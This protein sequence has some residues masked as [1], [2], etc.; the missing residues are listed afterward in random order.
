MAKKALLDV[1]EQTIGKYVKNL[2]AESLNVAVWSGKIELHSL[3]LDVE[4]VNNELDRQAAEAPNL[5]LPF[6]VLSGKFEAFEVD[7]PWSQI[8]SRPVVLR[9]QGLKVE[10]EP[11]DRLAQADH[12]K[13][14]VASETTRAANIRRAREKSIE[15]SDKYRQQA[16][17]MKKLAFAESTTENKSSFGSRLVRRIIENIQIEIVDV[18]ISLTDMDGSAGVVLESLS[19]VTTDKEGKK[20]FIDRTNQ[21]SLDNLFLYKMLQIKGFGIYLD[22]FSFQ[23]TRD[24]MPISESERCEPKEPS[25]SFILAPLSFEARLRQADSNVCVDFSKYHL[26]SELSSLS[27]ILSRNQL[28]LARK[29]SK[30][31]SSTESVACPL[32]PEYRPM[33]RV[34]KETARDWW[35]YATRCIGRLNGRRSWVEFFLAFQKRKKYIPLYKRQA[36]H[37][38]CPWIKPLS[39]E[40]A[41]ELMEIEHDRTLSVDGLM[42]WRNLA[43][44]QVDREREKHA[45]TQPEEQPKSYFSSV[46]RSRAKTIT[47]AQNDDDA[48]IELTPDELK[49]IE[50]MSKEEFT[51]PELSKDS[52]LCDVQFILNALKINLTSYDLRHVAALDMGTVSVDFEAAAN[53]AFSF[54][55]DLFDLEIQDRATPNSLFPSVLRSIKNKPMD[56][57]DREGAF[58]FHLSKAKSGDQNLR[59]KLAQFEAVASQVLF[60]E[61]KRFFSTVPIKRKKSSQLNPL[62]AQ[63][64]SGSVDLF[65]DADEGGGSSVISP[66]TAIIDRPATTSTAVSDFS[67]VLFDAWKEKTETKVSWV[68]DVDIKAPL[69]IVPEKCNDPVANVL[70]FNL[71]HLQLKYGKIDPAQKVLQWF[72]DH[73]K[74]NPSDFLLDSGNI[75][76]NDL[77]FKVGKADGWRLLLDSETLNETSDSAVI[78]PIS[79]LLDFGVESIS[80]TETPRVCCFGVIPTISLRLSPSQGFKIFPVINSWNDCLDEMNEGNHANNNVQDVDPNLDAVALTRPLSTNS[81]DKGSSSVAEPGSS[82]QENASGECH[83]TFYFLV[84]LQRL[85]VVVTK[86]PSNKLEAHLVS[87]YAST[88]IMSDGSSVNGLRMGWFWILDRMQC[89]YPRRQRLLAHSNLPL[90]PQFFAEGEKYNVLEEL[91]KQGVFERDYGGSTELADISF[92][93]RGFEIHDTET[94]DENSIHSVLDAS[95]SSLFIH[96]N[97]HAVKGINAMIKSLTSLVDEYGAHDSNGLI[98]SPEKAPKRRNS[99][100][101]GEQNSYQEKPLGGRMLI[102][103]KMESLDINLNSALDD[104]PLFVLTVSNAQVNILSSNSNET[105]IEASLSLGDLRMRTPD[106]MG[107][108]LPSY[109]TLIGLAPGRTESLLTVKY[110]L[111]QRATS[112][113]DLDPAVTNRLEAFADVE[114]SP[115]R[116]CYIHS[117]VF[118]LMEYIT[119][120]IL[121][122]LTARAATSAAE[123]AR[124]IANSVAGE[125]LFVVRATSFEALL[126]QAATK[127]QFIAI[128]AG[129][130]DVEFHMFPDPGGSKTHVALSDVSLKDSN[131]NLMQEQPIRMSIDVK[132]PSDQVGSLDDQA[133]RVNVDISEASFVMTKSQYAQ[134]LST[135]DENTGEMELFL[136]HDS[137]PLSIETS[138]GSTNEKIERSLVKDDATAGLTHAGVEAVII[139][140]RMYL[141]VKIEV[142]ALQLCGISMLDPLVRIAAVSSSVE[143]Q[144]YPH[145]EKMACQVSLRNLVCEDRRSKAS[146]RQYRFLIDQAASDS[147]TENSCENLFHIGYNSGENESSVELQV[148]S[149]RVCLIPDAISEVLGFFRVEGRSEKPD[150]AKNDPHSVTLRQNLVRVDSGGRGEDIEATLVPSYELAVSSYS[151][152]TKTCRIVLVD[153]GSQLASE[154]AP[155]QNIQLTETLV[156]Q[157]VFAAS[158]SMAT[159]INSGKLINADFQ[160]NG[161]AMEIFSAFGTEMKSP[162]QLLEPAECS[163][164]GSLKT[165][166][167]GRTEMEIRAATLTPFEIIFSMHN[168]ALL[169]AILNSLSESF[170][171]V[172]STEKEDAQKCLSPKEAER[173]EHLASALEATKTTD[174]I[175]YK[176]SLSMDDASAAT[177]NNGAEGRIW[178]RKFQLKLTMPEARVT[179][180]ND[181]QGLDE[182]LFRFS[183]VNFVAGGEVENSKNQPSSRSMLFDFHL[184]TSVLADYFDASLN[185]WSK[186]LIKPW[187][188]TLKGIRSPSRRF[189]SERLS[190]TIDL[191]SFPCCVSFSEQFLVSLAFPKI[192]RGMVCSVALCL[193]SFSFIIGESCKRLSNVVDLLYCNSNPSR[194]KIITR[195]RRNQHSQFEA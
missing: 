59:L 58:N 78:D 16:Y 62:L 155:E 186:L 31:I 192:G 127:V 182:A 37:A 147:M 181:L 33:A 173:I 23:P 44:S 149:P 39:T 80:P 137:L 104:F 157:G 141:N 109:R 122:A 53:G 64:L 126:P 18:H 1:L 161:D 184:N 102:K 70:V 52:K 45:A 167:T 29:I 24:L 60:R 145:A 81:G 118:A 12:L 55:F 123:A 77:T 148:G 8:T 195:F 103:A 32:F 185:L 134:I 54:N 34:S 49:E 113:V 42:S 47:I 188:I 119:E 130:L 98:L 19:L 88:S 5:A 106:G 99:L 3:V 9:A 183:V 189:N 67:N 14:V 84:G 132:L 85:S 73:P 128:H 131:E 165:T 91:T 87:V 174:K 40:E 121:G 30:E 90:P 139:L 97:P 187:E 75:A 153:L 152:S 27:I 69:L 178:T 83:S 171:N 15:A 117:Q 142:L 63:S 160:S 38:S 68:L 177:S 93:K 72:E 193:C 56:K 146:A 176:E 6:K 125:K 111:G 86:D 135:L 95:F 144:K 28:D 101:A 11:Y 168:A 110:F 79:V 57:E 25:H 175:L 138:D 154:I 156:L 114:L 194:R 76:I 180:V 140:R 92:K 48:P 115:M 169:S 35:K 100:V 120:G 22:Q 179:V 116:L 2:D 66:P 10:V 112:R 61:L 162:L 105:D 71:G 170:A 26:S 7:V 172:E 51:D 65:Y 166:N 143:L 108:T 191:E 94:V 21:A 82:V 158:L 159:D 41:K 136:R 4:A 163:A 89:D 164:H 13:A 43:E 96:W 124:E 46:F 133:M 74:H 107:Q 36:H 129:S 151:V 20:V 190:T 150:M 50:A 17:A